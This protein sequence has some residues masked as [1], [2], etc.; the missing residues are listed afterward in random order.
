[1]SGDDSLI[2]W[3][4]DLDS[5]ISVDFSDEYEAERKSEIL[6]E[7]L[8]QI[9]E[10]PL[11]AEKSISSRT[12]WSRGIDPDA[13][14][15][16]LHEAEIAL[17]DAS[18]QPEIER[19]F[20]GKLIKMGRGHAIRRYARWENLPYSTA[21]TATFPHGIRAL[22]YQYFDAEKSLCGSSKRPSVQNA[23][24]KA[25]KTESLTAY[26]QA[27]LV[28]QVLHSSARLVH[29]PAGH[30]DLD[31]NR[32]R[33]ILS[34]CRLHFLVRENDL[35]SLEALK[36]LERCY[37]NARSAI[38]NEKM[39]DHRITGRIIRNWKMRH[40]HP[41]TFFFPYSARNAIARGYKQ[42]YEDPKSFDRRRAVNELALV[43]C[44]MKL[45]RQH[46]IDRRKPK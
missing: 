11:F 38:K 37:S 43:H 45:M 14:R 6:E 33:T 3:V 4:G 19:L 18:K 26:D 44:G 13:W 21:L 9:G 16:S 32:T 10:I 41:L 25:F 30:F 8:D 42:V 2:I 36:K 27:G 39:T 17:C 24:Q 29:G 40:L 12:L 23:L 46:S 35:N 5:W 7:E 22:V 20:V 31:K 15:W 28:Q 1:M 34:L